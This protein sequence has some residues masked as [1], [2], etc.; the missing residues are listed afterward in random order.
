MLVTDYNITIITQQKYDT[1]IILYKYIYEKKK[2]SKL[3]T[4]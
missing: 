3:N 2:T 1:N 4:Y